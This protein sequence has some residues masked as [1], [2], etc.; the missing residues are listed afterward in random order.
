ML[1]ND[2]DRTEPPVK[3]VLFKMIEL[4]RPK[5][6]AGKTHARNSDVVAVVRVLVKHG[7]NVNLSLAP[8]VSP[9]VLPVVPVLPVLRRSSHLC[10]RFPPQHRGTPANTG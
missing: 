4:G 1:E 8:K 7:Y 9:A 10:P 5:H 6:E 3:D 2:F